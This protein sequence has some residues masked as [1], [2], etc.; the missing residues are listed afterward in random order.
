MLE[1]P[2]PSISRNADRSPPAVAALK[3][4]Y[5]LM[6]QRIISDP[7]SMM[8][9]LLYGTEASKFYGE[10]GSSPGGF[11]YPHCYLLNDL[12][13]PEAE[14][15]KDLKR[16]V[17]VEQ[18]D[19]E[20]L[21][22]SKDTVS[23]ANVLF[24][25]N[26][27]FTTKAPNFSSRRLF[28]VTDNDNPH[29]TDKA[30]RTSATVRAKDLYDLGVTLELF[31]ISSSSH[32]FD[33]S[34]FYDDI[35]YSSS[36][37]DP[38]APFYSPSSLSIPQ[39]EL[40]IGD[41]N[42]LSLLTSLLSSIFSK[43]TPKRTLFS[44]VPLEI[45]PGFRISVKGYLLYKLQEPAR[46]CYV[47]LGGDQPQIARG[48]TTQTA[49]DSDRTVEK[50][51][52]RKAYTFGG[53][54]VSFLPEEITSLRYFGP[55]V[56][57]LI[58]FKPLEYL[59][60]WANVKQSTFLYPSEEDFVGSSRCFTALYRKLVKSRL[61]GLTW[62][63]ARRNAAPVIAA[64]VPTLPSNPDLLHPRDG[65]SATGCPQ[66]LHL[67]PLPFADDIRQNPP[68]PQE[69]PLR[70][71]DGLIDAMRPLIGQLTLPKGVYDPARYP[72]PALQWHYRILQALAL[73]EDLPDKP[74]DKTIPK[75]RQIDK[76]VGREVIEWGQ[77]LERAYKEHQMS[78]LYVPSSTIKRE[79]PAAAATA[80]SLEKKNKGEQTASMTDAEV[81]K[82][83]QMGK[84]SK[85]TLPQLK[86]WLG[87]KKLPFTGKK[88]DLIARV[89]QWCDTT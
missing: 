78:D 31:P 86:G 20:I 11:S 71:P 42:G 45:A 14:D 18:T 53:E 23:M 16:L 32:T 27:I 50:F 17:E 8:G 40:K 28:I 79:R 49:D 59:P 70:A 44:S 47:Y 34:T 75:Y 73:D 61:M 58:G 72:N 67:I 37:A 6:Q 55:P 13:V 56:I 48:S 9:I 3:C 89:E 83:W 51:E 26:Q 81:R 39:T 80:G 15:V 7:K 1:V 36:P 2:S 46:S 43:S 33:T 4:A 57:R 74:E 82:L 68:M 35:I 38:D 41:V 5:H 21:K 30:M 25:A 84:T 54:Q 60:S 19:S 65:I 77:E 87:T 76:R 66:G 22:P 69:Q 12:D 52:I 62:F 63:I 10:D 29:A 85:M 88:A 24:C 64:L